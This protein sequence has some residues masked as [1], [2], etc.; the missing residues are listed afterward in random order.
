MIEI[1]LSGAE[2]KWEVK[3][4]SQVC[5][6]VIHNGCIYMASGPLRCLDLATGQR[7]WQGGNFGHGSCLITAGDNKVIA[8]GNGQLVLAEAYPSDGQY[9]E[10]SHVKDIVPD[11]C[12]P[13][14]ILSNGIICC[15]DKAGN[16][17]CFSI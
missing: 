4:F 10:L 13:H 3:D 15:K 12:Y 17:V 9:H 11:I 14:V 5:S 2:K 1:S 16:M 8:F 6:P 7:K